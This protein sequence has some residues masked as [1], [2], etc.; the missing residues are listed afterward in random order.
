MRKL[1][2]KEWNEQSWK[3]GFGCIVLS[4]LAFIG[5]RARIV[6]DETIEMYVCF[7]GLALLPILSSTGL[8]PA[9][10]DDGT[11][12]SLLALPVTPR[13]ILAAKTISGILLCAGPMIAAAAVSLAVAANRE[14]TVA[15]TIMLYVR[16]T[17]TALSL[18]IWMHALTVRLPTEARAALLALGLLILWLI[19]SIGL[20]NSRVPPIVVAI[21][22]LSFIHYGIDTNLGAPS[23]LAALGVQLCIA[24]VLWLWASRSL[25]KGSH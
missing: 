5:L 18:F 6:P 10:H 14:M 20:V 3:L 11:M 17:L 15:A 19:A 23:L 25:I 16:S 4:T 9:E 12:E 8:I 21:S 2:W 7:L 24:T 13:C 1:L 22:P